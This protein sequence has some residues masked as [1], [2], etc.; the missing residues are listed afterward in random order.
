MSYCFP[1]WPSAHTYTGIWNDMVSRYGTTLATATLAATDHAIIVS[2]VIT[3]TQG[4]ATLEPL[5][6]LDAPSALPAPAPGSYT[7][8]FKDAAGDVLASYP[9]EPDTPVELATTT[10]DEP[11]LRSFVLAL[12]WPAGVARVEL[13]RGEQLLATRSASASPP[14]VTVTNPNGGEN[15]SSA[16]VTLSWNASDP[17]GD[18]LVYVV[19][20]SRDNG[21][22]WETIA[23]DLSATTL[24]LDPADFPGGD[25]SLFRVQA[26]D[27]FHTAVDQSDAVFS[28]ARHAPEAFIE[29]L[30]NGG[31]Y[32][33]EQMLLLDGSAYD[34]EDGMLPA[35]AL[36]WSSNRDG[37][38]DI[39][40]ELTRGVAAM[41]A[42]THTITLTAT[43][44]DGQSATASVTIQVYRE[45]PTLPAGF[46]LAPGEMGLV[47]SLASNTTL[48]RTLTLRNS[49][50]GELNWSA[51]ADQPWASLSSTSGSAP[52]DLVLTLDP[53]GLAAGEHTATIAFSA[54]DVTAQAINVYLYVQEA[55]SNPRIY[56]PLVRR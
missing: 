54:P 36:R 49:G 22:T 4:T 10:S 47:A 3:P 44:S 29:G 9:F 45:R 33:G 38:L 52:A 19:Q 21:A 34:R 46:S 31:M 7:L 15:L 23:L 51:S 56:L 20:Y 30:A 39:G 14:T 8:R 6:T 55:P 50:D 18:P 48:T 40:A 24:E 26:S 11:D 12:P 32:V 27:G 13:L 43:D 41:S 53:R 1:N 28:V 42:G 2:G 37:A 16:P 35:T 5:Y 17:D 25:Q